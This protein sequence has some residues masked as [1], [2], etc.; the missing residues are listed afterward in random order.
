M[1]T[2]SKIL[3]SYLSPYIRY[4]IINEIISAHKFSFLV[5]NLRD[6]II[7]L[8]YESLSDTYTNIND[9]NDDIVD[10]IM[11]FQDIFSIKLVKI[12]NVLINCIFYYII[13]PLIISAF[14]TLK[15]VILI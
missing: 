10:I 2:Y 3:G 9:I 11:Y 15:K 1:G 12:N 6:L 4:S 5:L 13:F 14:T 7:K 8:N